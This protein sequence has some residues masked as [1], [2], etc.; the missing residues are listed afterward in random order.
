MLIAVPSDNADGL[1]AAISEHFGHCAVFTL[2]DVVDDT[3]GKV[4]IL[5]NAP[6]EQG[7]CM[8]PVNFL[9]QHGVE[10]LL[11]GGMGMRPLSGFQ[12]VGI[13]VH[14]KG[15]ANSV[16]EAVEL[17]LSGGCRAF[18]DAQTCGGGGDG[19]GDQDPHHD[20][21][22]QTGPEIVAID[23]PADVREGRLVTLE[24]ELKDSG[25]ELLDSSA[26]SG[27]IRFIFG[28]GQ[29]LPALE[30]AVAGLEPGANVVKEIPATEGFG[31]R[32]ES[33]VIEAPRTQLPP[34]VC[35]GAMV[36]AEDGQG[37]QFPL[38][39]IH[40]DE[41]IVRLDGNHP[42]AGKDLVFD[43]TVSKVEGIKTAAAPAD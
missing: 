35:V 4:T 16:R 7:G 27:P 11:A 30:Q 41:N 38:T 26:A 22:Q 32:E 21:H 1:D 39:V 6:H 36:T 5:E 14:F 18:D 15:D 33:R 23:G 34:D 24:F 3:I 40:L 31:E 25:G 43:L 12:E 20:H 19:C 8:A 10:I 28:A 42:F 17:F 2:I 13:D 29:T 37:R 9:K